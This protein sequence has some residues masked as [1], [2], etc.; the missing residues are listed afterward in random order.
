[1]KKIIIAILFMVMA[2]ACLAGGIPSTHFDISSFST[3]KIENVVVIAPTKSK[4]SYQRLKQKYESEVFY[5]E[6]LRDRI[7]LLQ[8]EN[9]NEQKVLEKCLV[10]TPVIIETEVIKKSNCL[11]VVI[12]GSII[13]FML[14]LM[15]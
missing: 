5:N 2:Q 4:S 6:E 15:F 8:S 9:Y 7:I 12:I 1:M 11:P 13:G 10:Q 14:G 3:E